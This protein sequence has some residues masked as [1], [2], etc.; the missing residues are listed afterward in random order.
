MTDEGIVVYI[1]QAKYFQ[2]NNIDINN[3]EEMLKCSFKLLPDNWSSFDNK[4][5]LK[6]LAQAIK[7]NRNLKSLYEDYYL[8]NG[9]IL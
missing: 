7:E 8:E 3:V 6:L 4:L 2:I 9:M 5:K 1:L